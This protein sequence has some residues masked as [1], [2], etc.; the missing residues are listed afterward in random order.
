MAQTFDYVTKL[1]YDLFSYQENKMEQVRSF[2]NDVAVNLWNVW[3]PDF[4]LVIFYQKPAGGRDH[5]K[6]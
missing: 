2:G 6:M 5:L 3:S 1:H 4:M